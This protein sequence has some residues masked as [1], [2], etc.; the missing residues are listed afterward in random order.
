MTAW[1][2]IIAVALVVVLVARER[3]HSW[4]SVRKSVARL[5]RKVRN[6][7]LDRFRKVPPEGHYL[8]ERYGMAE[9][10]P[11]WNR[12][13]LSWFQCGPERRQP[14]EDFRRAFKERAKEPSVLST[15][16]QRH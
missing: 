7:V 9:K 4:K 1:L 12:A 13:V 5:F 2:L 10:P 6:R 14:N 11:G 8:M 16:G 15:L 3:Q